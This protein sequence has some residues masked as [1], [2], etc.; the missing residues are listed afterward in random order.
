MIRAID[1]ANIK[2]FCVEARPHK[3]FCRANWWRDMDIIL[4]EAQRRDMKVWILDDKHFPTGYA[5]GGALSA[6]LQ[7][8]RRSL[9]RQS[10][11]VRGGRIIELELEKYIHP[12]PKFSAISLGLQLYTGGGKLPQ[13]LGTDEL[14]SVTACS[15]SQCIDLM[16]HISGGRLCWKAPAGDWSIQICSLSHNAGTHRDYI[17][18]MD[19]DACRIQIDQVYEP[20]FAHY[21]DQFGTVIAGFFSDEPELGNGDYLNHGNVLGTEQDLPWSDELAD[22]LAQRLGEGWQSQL[23][24]LWYNGHDAAETARVRYAYMDTVTRLVEEDFSRQIGE[25]CQSHGVEYIGHVIEDNNQHARTSTSLGHYFRGLKYQTMAGIDDIGGQVHPGGEDAHIRSIMGFTSDGEFYHYAL[26]KLGASLGALNPRMQGRAMCEIF[27]NY[28]WSEG[29]RLE[30]YLLDHFLVRGI[31]YFV[32]HAFTCSSYPERDCPPHFYAQ[33]HNPQYR[34]FGALM[35]YANRMSS[36]LSGGRVVAPVAILY[37]GEAEWTGRCMLMQKPARALQDRQIDFLFVPSDVFAEREFYRTKLGA[38]LVVNGQGFHAVV[39]PY[40]QFLTP[41]TA[42]AL[43]ELREHGCRVILLEN[44]PDGLTDGSPIPAALKACEIMPLEALAAQLVDLQT[45]RLDPASDRIR[46]L[47]YRGDQE[48]LLLVNEGGTIYEGTTRLPLKGPLCVYDPWNNRLEQLDSFADGSIRLRLEPSHALVIV[49]RDDR[50]AETPLRL[51]G[52]VTEL[53]NF[54]RCV[55]RGIDYPHFGPAE[56]V[57]DIEPYSRRHPGFSG[58]L[59]YETE[60]LAGEH[61]TGLEIADAGEA[62]EVFVNG[63]SAGIQIVPGFR[64][65]LTPLCQT[66]K[67]RLRIE[68]ATTLERERGG[69]KNAAPTGLLGPVRLYRE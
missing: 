17:N 26:G 22:R 57:K 29:V 42:D 62:V 46:V 59:R 24:L 56:S 9:C 25:W 44:V 4:D 18:M 69:R 35:Q 31:N 63:H 16:P 12:K 8:R 6:P 38:Q 19:R 50:M 20:H 54:T 65:D 52:Q 36:L 41:E 23:A 68:V 53:V 15:A 32:P 3:D 30:K 67:N 37:H 66:G 1:E 39:V 47:H 13:K 61:F 55:C 7:Q 40:A 34:H 60:I 27:G 21:G 58:I 28:G 45:L 49:P 33:G 51:R 14:F 10:V 5:N 2:A 11:E 43:L 48:L 64:Y